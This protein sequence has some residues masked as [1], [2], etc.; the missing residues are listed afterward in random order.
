MTMVSADL[1]RLISL[2]D[3]HRDYGERSYEQVVAEVRGGSLVLKE[4]PDGADLQPFITDRSTRLRVKGTGIMRSTRGFTKEAH[5]A[6][7]LW[8]ERA[9][10]DFSRVYGSLME[11]IT[12]KQDPRAMKIFFDHFLGQPMRSLEGGASTDAIQA[13]LAAAKTQQTVRYIDAETGEPR[14]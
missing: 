10:E 3:P 2:L 13:L 5:Y 14:D 8:M 11:A 4:R 7:A 9:S 12:V 6:K 1:E